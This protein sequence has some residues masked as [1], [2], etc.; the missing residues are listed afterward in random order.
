[1]ATAAEQP[2][3]PTLVRKLRRAASW[4]EV[5]T[6]LS[7]AGS[8]PDAVDLCTALHC[9]QNILGKEVQSMPE[10]EAEQLRGFVKTTLVLMLDRSSTQ[11]LGKGAQTMANALTS[12]ARLHI[13]PQRAIMAGLCSRAMRCCSEATPQALANTA[14]GLALLRVQPAEEAGLI[15]AVIQLSYEKVRFDLVD[16]PPVK[17]GHSSLLLKKT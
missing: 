6:I 1:M 9:T 7:S 2:Y 11:P 3:D 16:G 14:M 15:D 10:E 17:C 5:R 4:R 13:R 12:L 8:V